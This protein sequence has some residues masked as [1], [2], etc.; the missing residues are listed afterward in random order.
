MKLPVPPRPDAPGSVI[1]AV[2]LDPVG[3]GAPRAPATWGLGE[4]LAVY[5]VGNLLIGQI[6]VAGILV[7]L[8]GIEEIP[9]GGA[10]TDILAISA[11][12]AITFAASILAWFRIRHPGWRGIVGLPAGREAAREFRWGAV[13]GLIVYPIVAF[14]AGTIVV[15]VLSA[16]TGETVET[17]A[18]LSSD[19]SFAGRVLAAG[20]A[21]LVA[22]VVEELYFRG[23]LLRSMLERRGFWP[24]AIV[25]SLVFGLVHWPIGEALGDALVLPIVMTVTGFALAWIYSRRRNIVACVAAH[26]VFNTIGIVLIFSG[27]G[28]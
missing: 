14:A 5:L 8:L 16:L 24:A 27:I 26:M 13:A 7:V 25:S 2:G 15:I 3:D 9:T 17:P 12:V 10:G 28:E 6:V 21:I 22:P 4:A 1:D 23:V 11:A 19:L 18:Q 20:Y